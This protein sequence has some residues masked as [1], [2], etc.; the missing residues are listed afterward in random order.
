M[1]PRSIPKPKH[2]PQ[3]RLPAHELFPQPGVYRPQ[4]FQRPPQPSRNPP[5]WLWGVVFLCMLVLGFGLFGWLKRPHL[6]TPIALVEVRALEVNGHPVAAARL[7]INGK[8]MGVT[9][10]FGEW[11]RYMRLAAGE[12]LLIEL[13]KSGQE[14]LRGKKTIRVGS[15]RNGEKSPE[16]RVSIEMR[17]GAKIAKAPARAAPVRRDAPEDSE[18]FQD[19]P[20]EGGFE[21]PPAATSGRD[22]TERSQE[23]T[24]TEDDTIGDTNDA[25]L[26]IYFD[27]GLSA[28]SVQSKFVRKA[29][30]NLLEKHQGEILQRK[31]MPLL[32]GDLQKLGLR[33]EKNAP[34]QLTLQYVP[35]E[36]QVG[37]IR[38]QIDWP[39]PFGQRES[40]AF[41]AG[42]SKTFDE[43]VRALSSL[44]RVHMKK[45]YW[46]FK[47]NGRWYIDEPSDTKA[48]WRLRPGIELSDTNGLKFPLKLASQ[49]EGSKRWQ[50]NI[51]G[52]Q[53]CYNVRQRLRCLVT[54]Q[55]L[56]DS[57]PLLGWQKR[58]MQMQ[59]SLPKNAEL[60]VAGFQ[61]NPLGGGRWEYWGHPGSNHKALVMSQGR[62]LHSEVFIDRAATQTVLRVPPPSHLRQARR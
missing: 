48:F 45:S 7:S 13:S 47:D 5:P 24:E 33:V 27:D 4:N 16:V 58:Q 14:Q 52:Q 20:E 9:D 35:K 28:I 43:T 50:L 38:A 19:D 25:S 1:K 30:S 44:L 17:G 56:K 59:G 54:T 8:P 62:V 12:Q 37:Y 22:V 11:R 10:S 39:N 41:I 23:E 61:A 40:T 2:K 26:G 51:N 18:F 46:A 6:Q 55:S 32:V 31:I 57:P 42:F 49:R 29:P 15:L 34:W 21:S 53:P 36:D 3:M 60:F